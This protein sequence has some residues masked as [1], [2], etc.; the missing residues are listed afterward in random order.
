MADRHPGRAGGSCNEEEEEEEEE[1]D[2]KNKHAVSLMSTPPL[3]QSLGSPSPLTH[4]AEEANEDG[5]H[6]PP[7]RGRAPVRP[8]DGSQAVG[9]HGISD[10]EEVRGRQPLVLCQEIFHALLQLWV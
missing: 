7:R 2:T 5:V 9:H 10:L 1:E 6:H 8:R 3:T 4:R